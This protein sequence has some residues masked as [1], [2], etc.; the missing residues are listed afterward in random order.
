MNSITPAFPFRIETKSA[1]GLLIV[2]IAYTPENAAQ[3]IAKLTL[4]FPDAKFAS[5]P[6]DVLFVDTPA[7]PGELA[8]LL[9]FEQ[10]VFDNTGTKD[11]HTMGRAFRTVEKLE[12]HTAA[13]A[14]REAAATARETALTAPPP[15]PPPC[16]VGFL[17]GD[18]IRCKHSGRVAEAIEL[19]DDVII[20]KEPGALAAH[21]IPRECG[22]DFEK[23]SKASAK[24]YVA[25]A[26]K[27]AKD[28]AAVAQSA[29]DAAAIVQ[30]QFPF[31]VGA[32][33]ANDHSPDLI[34]VTAIGTDSQKGGFDW[35]HTDPAAK[36]QSGSC[37]INAIGNFRVHGAARDHAEKKAGRVAVVPAVA[38]RRTPAAPRSAPR[39]SKAP[40]KPNARKK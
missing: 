6:N 16:K 12:K 39:H 25:A 36:E 40:A 28:A 21:P 9:K 11:P 4:A 32:V 35:V 7:D 37:A 24:P 22:A 5:V 3:K 33:L 17:A 29:I 38:K 31:A 15:P 13:V 26:A 2:D 30:P 10:E 19:R 14:A 27:G 23:L 1:A 34:R 18:F 20:L 8:R